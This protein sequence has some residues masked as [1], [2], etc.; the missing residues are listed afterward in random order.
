MDLACRR[1]GLGSS[2][3]LRTSF[4]L[5]R[6]VTSSSLPGRGAEDER[7]TRREKAKRRLRRVERLGYMLDGVAEKRALAL[8]LV[9]GTSRCGERGEDLC[10]DRES[11]GDL[12]I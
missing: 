3:R 8:S 6:Y 9:D 2:R 12:G 1:P 4:G 11:W 10:L 5:S 7:E